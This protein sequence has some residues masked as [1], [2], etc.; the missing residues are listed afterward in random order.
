MIIELSHIL[1]CTHYPTASGIKFEVDR[2]ICYTQTNEESN[3]RMD[4]RKASTL[5]RAYKIIDKALLKT[6]EVGN[7][8]DI[9]L[10][11]NIIHQV[12]FSLVLHG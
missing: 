3:R 7:E 6:I 10:L 1:T 12:M 9:C 5:S 11:H 4:Y 8:K 2:K